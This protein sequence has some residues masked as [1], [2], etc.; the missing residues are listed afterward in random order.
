MSA[1]L[2]FFPNL[3]PVGAAVDRRTCAGVIVHAPTRCDMR[4]MGS[5]TSVLPDG[6]TAEAKWDDGQKK[7][8][9][10][11]GSIAGR[12]DTALSANK[13]QLANAASVNWDL[14]DLSEAGNDIGHGLAQDN[15]GLVQCN[16]RLYNLLLKNWGDAEGSVGTLTVGA[17]AS[18]EWSGFLEPSGTI[19]LLTDTEVALIAESPNG[20]EVSDTDAFLKVAASGGAVVY[21]LNYNSCSQ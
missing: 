5:Y 15:L 20:M 4:I 21:G 2:F 10:Q 19:K 11:D 17:A 7:I 1:L 8:D 14:Y 16:Q 18:N 3:T 9:Y 12:C 13:L 6:Q